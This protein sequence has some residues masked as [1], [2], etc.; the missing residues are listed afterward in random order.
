MLK[1]DAPIE[2]FTPY[3]D[4][5]LLHS[6]R[7][8]IAFIR[9][10]MSIDFLLFTTTPKE[11]IGVFFVHKSDGQRIL[12]L[13]LG[14]LIVISVNLLALN[15]AVLKGLLALRL[16]SQRNARIVQPRSSTSWSEEACASG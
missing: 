11:H 7:H 10:L 2:S 12:L 1:E 5:C 3:W 6:K 4:P 14:L 8:Y 13:M 15:S 16:D 9:K